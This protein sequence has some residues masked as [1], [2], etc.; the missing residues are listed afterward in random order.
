MNKPDLSEID[1]KYGIFSKMS[2]PYLGPSSNYMTNK[3]IKFWCDINGVKY[4]DTDKRIDLIERIKN[5]GYR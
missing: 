5:A 3:D 1:Y 4:E 2:K